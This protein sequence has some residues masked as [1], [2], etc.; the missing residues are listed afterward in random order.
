MKIN[1]AQ[2]SKDNSQSVEILLIETFACCPHLE[3]SGEIA[4]EFSKKG[5]KVGIVFI[6]VDNP[7]D[8]TPKRNFFIPKSRQNRVKALFRVLSD[9]NIK[10]HF[11]EVPDKS[12]KSIIY[13]LFE[14][15]KEQI[16][17]CN[18]INCI[19]KIKLNDIK[20]GMGVASSYVSYMRDP[21][22]CIDKNLIKRYFKS[23]IATYVITEKLLQRFSPHK[24]ITY[25]GRFACSKPIVDVCKKYSIPLLYHERGATKERY[26]LSEKS[27]HDFKAIRAS[28]KEMWESS[29]DENKEKIAESYFLRKIKGETIGWVSFTENQIKGLIPEKSKKYRWTYY[30]SSDDEFIYVEDYIENPIFKSQTEAI[31]WL[32]D[33]VGNLDDV[34]LVIRVHPHKQQKSQKLRDF[35]NNLNGR[36][37]LVVPSHS[38]VDSYA[39]AKSSDLV[40]VYNSTIGVE[41][42]Y[43]GKAVITIDDALYKSLNCTYEPLSLQELDNYLSL[44]KLQ[45]KEIKNVL[46]F[47]YYHMLYGNLFLYYK[48]YSLFYGKFVDTYLCYYEENTIFSKLNKIKFKFVLFIR[49]I[50]KFLF[51][52]KRR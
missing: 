52:N 7:D 12:D 46:P 6:D 30:S 26:Y 11:I 41:A 39:L 43:L 24:V 29:L 42:A 1:D 22:P 16:E 9:F 51:V 47:G 37:V 8:Y 31:K 27:P 38:P 21:E 20:I 5:F 14:E 17:N 48:P 23:A 25:N 13:L 28:I 18:D 50:K 32:I 49:V 3:T 4:I 44:K 33:Y 2:G 34:E 36:N 45:S 35:W 19:K 10:N 40:I 15:I